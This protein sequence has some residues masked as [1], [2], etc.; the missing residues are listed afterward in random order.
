MIAG[1]QN[2]FTRQFNGNEQLYNQAKAF[3]NGLDA[4]MWIV[5]IAMI[6]IG[7]GLAA[8][9]YTAYNN[10]PGRHYKPT[11]W[12]VFL[13]VTFIATLLVSLGIQYVLCPPKLNGAQTLE[14]NI[15]LGNS[16][17]AC[18]VYFVTSVV[19]CNAFP[20]NA[21]RIFKPTKR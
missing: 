11:H 13:G 18:I 5:V 19:W 4:S 15:A 2:D 7:I 1:T 3:W 10:K 20:T 12:I 6:V 16:L 17:Y 9:Y 14:L 8:Y 21:Y